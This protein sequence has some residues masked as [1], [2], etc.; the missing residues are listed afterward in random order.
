L[1]DYNEQLRGA[2]VVLVPDNDD[3]GHKHIQEV[4]AALSNIAARLRVLMLPDLPAKGDVSNWLSAGGTREV[5]DEL[6]EQAADWQ[7]PA[8]EEP[9]DADAQKKTEAE[10]REKELLD[11]LAR[12]N[13]LDYEKR[14]EQ[15]AR[16]LGIRRGALDGEVEA[17]PR[18]QAEEAGPAPLFGHWVVEPWPDPVDPAE[19]LEDV[20]RQIHRY[21]I[22]PDHLADASAMWAQIGWNLDIA[23]HSPMLLIGSSDP[24]SGKTTLL[25]VLGFLVRRPLSTVDITEAA[26]FRSIERWEPG[27][28]VDE[29]DDTFKKKRAG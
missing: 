5:L 12:L 7:P 16:E 20:T 19:L 17:R 4:G 23:T 21:S 8:S 2:D 25:D 24:N 3:A 27:I 26:L 14:R 6:I 18:E 29:G 22:I 15:A 28:L 11:E 10:A 9:A 13:R 1:P